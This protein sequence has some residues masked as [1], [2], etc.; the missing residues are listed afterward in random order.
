MRVPPV[1]R[2]AA[3]LVALLGTQL[4]A[5]ACALVVAVPAGA[6]LTTFGS[7]LSAPA[8]LNTAENLNYRGTDTAVL[9]S[10][11]A[12]SGVVHTYHYGADTAI[13]NVAVAGHSAAAPASGQAVEVRLEGCAVP[14]QGG[15]APLTQIHFQALAPTPNGRVKV[16]L[17]SAGYDIPVCG[18]G[19]ASGATVTS[20]EPVNLCVN[21]GDYVAFNDEGGFVEHSYQSG[22]PY[23][24]LGSGGGSSFDSFIRGGGTNNGALFSPA[25]TSSMDGFVGSQGRELMMQVTLGTGPDARYVCPG[26]SKDAPV[27][28]GPISVHPQ[29][30]GI[31]HARVA[32]VAIFCRPAS[33]CAGTA[34]LTLAGKRVSIGSASFNLPGSTTSHVPIRLVPQVMRLIRARH[35]V[36]ATLTVS[37]AGARV[38]QAITVK[39]F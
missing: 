3:R 8:T 18:N 25:D 17:T 26:G 36:S 11:E 32:S 12:P 2:R 7:P 38:S 20:Y 35:G 16:A 30:D 9:P 14:A 39:I 31:N 33:G 6:A 23:K 19:G 21:Q 37:A 13:W 27:V 29:T 1:S 4:G 34:A 10:A 24:V 28:Y 22:V 5:L 15:P